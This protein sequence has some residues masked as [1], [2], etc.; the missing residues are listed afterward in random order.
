ML[1]PVLLFVV[2]GI[3]GTL[4]ALRLQA[5]DAQ[6]HRSILTRRG[7]IVVAI[8]I[9]I[10]VAFFVVFLNGVWWNCDTGECSFVW[11]Y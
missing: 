9:G 10:G 2:A 6:E 5:I 4:I 8:G 1:F 11:G 3:V 7:R